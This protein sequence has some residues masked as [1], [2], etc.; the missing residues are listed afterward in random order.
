MPSAVNLL[1]QK[2]A[3][4]LRARLFLNDAFEAEAVV[5]ACRFSANFTQT[6]NS[7][8][9]QRGIFFGVSRGWGEATLPMQAMP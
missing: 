4:L 1:V 8:C 5:P 2:T 7:F 9:P 3:W 6:Q